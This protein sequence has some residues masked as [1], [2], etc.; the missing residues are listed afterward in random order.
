MVMIV[1]MSDHDTYN[2]HGYDGRGG[3][4]DDDICG[5]DCDFINGENIDGNDGN[6][7]ADDFD[8]HE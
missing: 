1:M 3:S 5:D 6:N 7:D 2:G 4:C 8:D